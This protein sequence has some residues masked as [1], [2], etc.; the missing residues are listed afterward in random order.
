MF[1]IYIVPISGSLGSPPPDPDVL[2][3][4][5]RLRKSATTLFNH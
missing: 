1:L 5:I 3:L 2:I 4:L